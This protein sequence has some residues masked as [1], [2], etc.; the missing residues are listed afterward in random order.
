MPEFKRPQ[1]RAVAKLLAHLDAA[2]LAEAQS[3]FGGDTRIALAF[4]E[5][6]ESR[7]VG[8]LCASRAG[9]R[10]LRETVSQ[11]SLGAIVRRPLPLARE[12]RADR[13]GIR[14]FVIVDDY[15]I[16]FE[17]LLEAR[18]ELQGKMDR[19]F[20]VPTL[21]VQHTIAEKFLAN[22]D[23]GLDASTA[24][25]DLVDLAFIAV[26]EDRQQVLNG[27]VLAEGAYGTAVRRHLK[28]TLDHLA[29]ERTRL[30]AAAIALGITD[31]ATLKKGIKLLRQLN[32]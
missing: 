21:D 3:Y 1:H 11:D 29:A 8:F 15:K 27:L 22:A 6:R 9:F 32:G 30:G 31:V 16:K 18:I 12:V 10:Q 2:F 26:H 14:T 5:Y 13:D 4:G 28:L 25:R 24:Y 19:V 7:D 23:R 20:K 17:I